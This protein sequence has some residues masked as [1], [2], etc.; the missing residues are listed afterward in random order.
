MR[1]FL[2]YRV[3]GADFTLKEPKI[4]P[5]PPQPSLLFIFSDQQHWQ[6]RGCEDPFFDTP[7]VDAFAAESLFFERSFCSSPQCSPNRSTILSGVY[8][9]TTGPSTR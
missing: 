9:S 8:P 5:P 6:A 4:M 7:N 2:I 3:L 1:S